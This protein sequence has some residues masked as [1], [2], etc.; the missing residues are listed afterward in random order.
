MAEIKST[1]ELVMEKTSGLVQTE[2]DR[3]LEKARELEN[4]AK[5]ILLALEEGRETLEDLPNLIAGDD[6]DDLLSALICQTAE[7]LTLESAPSLYEVLSALC[8]KACSAPAE[9]ITSLAAEYQSRGSVLTQEASDRFLD[10][11][12]ARGISGS[13][14]SPNPDADPDYVLSLA[15]LRAEYETKLEKARGRI[16]ERLETSS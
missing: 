3:K 16:L 7:N 13:A 11:L 6:K 8:E 15:E 4:R 9:E 12:A 2:D 5:G 10:E 14:V 1:L